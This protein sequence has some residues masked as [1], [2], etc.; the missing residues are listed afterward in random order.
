MT[1]TS[2]SEAPCVSETMVGLPGARSEV[3]GRQASA[4]QLALPEGVTRAAPKAL[5]MLGD[6]A[7]AGAS[8]ARH[9]SAERTFVD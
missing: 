3:L 8:A 6:D 1:T 7:L 2:S 5:D 4:E 9:D